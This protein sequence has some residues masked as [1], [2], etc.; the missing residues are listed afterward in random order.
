MRSDNGLIVQS[1][2]FRAA[3]R[4]YNLSQEYITPYTPEQNG[5]IERLFRTVK[6]ECTWQHNF[7]SFREAKAAVSRW[8]GWY[9]EERP[10]SALGYQSPRE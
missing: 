5:M 7:A 2:R 8:I 1:R 6:E 4:D 10:H 3:C 9:N